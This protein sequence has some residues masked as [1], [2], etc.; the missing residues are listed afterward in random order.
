MAVSPSYVSGNFFAENP[1]SLSVLLNQLVKEVSLLMAESPRPPIPHSNILPSEQ[2]NPRVWGARRSFPIAAIVL[3][4]LVTGG[5]VWA[6]NVHGVT[7]GSNVANAGANTS[8]A[9]TSDGPVI[10]KT[11]HSVY[12]PVTTI[13]ATI[14]NTL[15]RAITSTALGNCSVLDLQQYLDGAWSDAA[16]TFCPVPPY[17]PMPNLTAVPEPIQLITI[18]AGATK[19]ITIK[20]RNL[21]M[22]HGYV[23]VP[24]T[25]RLQFQYSL[26]AG[27]VTS[28]TVVDSASFSVQGT[29][30][31]A[32]PAPNV[33]TVPP[34]SGTPY[35]GGA[36]NGCPAQQDPGNLPAPDL[37]I[38]NTTTNGNSAPLPGTPIKA[39]MRIGQLV[40]LQLPAGLQWQL[41]TNSATSIL[42]PHLPLGGYRVSNNSCIWRYTAMAAGVADLSFAGTAICPPNA[43]C[44]AIASPVEFVITIYGNA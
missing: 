40:E 23:F 29:L 26:A 38:T 24:G 30:P 16:S 7:A 14:H 25:Y 21:T 10:L 43:A 8:A 37:I 6:R 15:T 44:P 28:D 39:Q 42:Q 12:A 33:T 20:P 3:L 35:P 11:D 18:D 1:V 13:Y 9:T 19:A 32:T 36:I 5:F 22:G 34:P 27:Q 4:I 2:R 17:V 41:A 31:D